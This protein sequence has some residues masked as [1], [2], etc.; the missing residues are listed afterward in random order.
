[1]SGADGSAEAGKSRSAAHR[2]RDILKEGELNEGLI[3][4]GRSMTRDGR[5]YKHD[6]PYPN[7]KVLRSVV[8]F[9]HCRLVV[10][11]FMH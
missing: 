7:L 6:Y 5:V 8:I 3:N 2:R 9:V 1:M 10:V 11:G 4:I